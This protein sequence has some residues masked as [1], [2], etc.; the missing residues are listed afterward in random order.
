MPLF[1][2]YTDAEGAENIILSGK[3][4]V[5]LSFMAG[6]DTAFGNGVYFTKLSSETSIKI[7]IAKNN[8]ANTSAQFIRKTENYF[9][10]D[11]KESDVKDTN[12][13]DRNIFTFG[14]QNDLLLYK[15]PWWLKN[16]DSNQIIASYKYT[17]MFFGPA[18]SL[19][20]SI[21]KDCMKDYIVTEEI[22]NG[23]PVYKHADKFL[24]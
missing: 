20:Q 1:Q 16:F 21:I 15:Y 5:S 10:I 2:Y 24:K 8:W 11:I 6:G 19:S 14:S 9:V 4:K 13:T 17:I 3:I 7:Q 12:A 18:F 22:V 23:R